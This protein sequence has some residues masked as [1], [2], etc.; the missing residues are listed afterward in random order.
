MGV[1][2]EYLSWDGN[3]DDAILP[4]RVSTDNMGGDDLEN[5]E[6]NPPGPGEPDA[7]AWDSKVREIAALAKTAAAAK[8]TITYDG[9]APQI[10]LFAACGS[11]TSGDIELDDDDTG[12]V[13]IIW[14]EN[15]FPPAS[16][17]PHGLTL[18]AEGTGFAVNITN[19][20]RVT[21]KDAAAALA[22]I[23]FT[24]CIG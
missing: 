8:I 20:V 5:D 1:G 6:A 7:T 15:A 17:W 11:I 23:A 3:E 19:G 9:S 10:E 21:T 4:H 13:E 22:N 18:H 12:T 24:I 2:I 14:P 16:V